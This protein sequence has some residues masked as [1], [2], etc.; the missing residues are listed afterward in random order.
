MKKVLA[1]LIAVMLILSLAACG[2]S[3]TDTKS[4]STESPSVEATQAEEETEPV[5]EAP[6][7]TEANDDALIEE[8]TAKLVGDWTY[9]GMEDFVR[10]TFNEDGTGSYNGLDVTDLTFT[11]V[12]SME[13][14]E[15]GNGEAYIDKT[16][17]V[18]YNT[19]EAEEIVIDFL[20]EAQ[21]QLTFHTTDGGG[22]SGIIT[23]Y[24]GWIRA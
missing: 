22:Y 13:H 24:G 20:Q 7:S 19:G 15:Y 21:E 18:T 4:E 14:K 23:Y 2:N 11:Y 12:M 9:A 10:L 17:T 5:T 16:L 8:T 3:G 1:I 6:A